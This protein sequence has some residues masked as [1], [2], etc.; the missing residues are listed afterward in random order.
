MGN[1]PQPNLAKQGNL[2]HTSAIS[3]AKGWKDA[4]SHA[5]LTPQGFIAQPVQRARQIPEAPLCDIGYDADWPI[6]RTACAIVADSDVGTA[7]QPTAQHCTA[8]SSAG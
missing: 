8:V 7:Q 2:R 6:P 5:I 4:K 3:E 1:L